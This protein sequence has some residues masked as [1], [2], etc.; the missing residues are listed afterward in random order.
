MAYRI[1]KQARK[2]HLGKC[3]EKVC[4]NNT[5]TLIC[6][7]FLFS[8]LFRK[9]FHVNC[10]Q[11]GGFVATA[12]EACHPIG[13]TDPSRSPGKDPISRKAYRAFV[14]SGVLLTFG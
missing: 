10:E 14:L 8:F 11:N 7:I 1:R 5:R 13:V 6:L 9:G 3:M 2:K 12:H 4:K